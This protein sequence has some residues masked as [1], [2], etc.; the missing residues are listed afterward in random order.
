MYDMVSGSSPHTQGETLVNKPAPY[1]TG[2]DVNKF[3]DPS[4]GSLCKVVVAHDEAID[5]AE[6][7]NSSQFKPLLPPSVKGVESIFLLV[8]VMLGRAGHVFQTAVTSF[9][10]RT[11]TKLLICL[12]GVVVGDDD[13]NT[14]A[15][16]VID[17][18][19]GSTTATNK[20]YSIGRSSENS[21]LW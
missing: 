17:G 15:C 10:F 3:N 7:N 12:L 4:P 1:M 19:V 6:Y 9:L 20:K 8:L 5:C 21:L 14:K 18:S 2:N 13:G 11:K 16:T